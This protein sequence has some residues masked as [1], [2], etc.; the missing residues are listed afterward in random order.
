MRQSVGNYRRTIG[1][2]SQNIGERENGLLPMEPSGKCMSRTCWQNIT[3][4]MEGTEVLGIIMCQ[5][6]ISHL[7]SRFIPC[8]VHGGGVYPR[9]V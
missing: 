7:F 1:F 6:R 2:I 4:D 9:Y 8:G 3:L 5:I